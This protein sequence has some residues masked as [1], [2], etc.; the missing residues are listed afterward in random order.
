MNTTVS[1]Q[2]RHFARVAFDAEVQLHFHLSKEV[3][4]AHLL[5]IS[6][7]GALFETKQPLVN[8]YYGKVCRIELALGRDGDQI[9]I[10]G[11]VVHQEGQLI[12]IE[13][14]HIDLDS[15]I[16]LRRLVEL[17]TGDPELLERELSELIKNDVRGTKPAS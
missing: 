10:E 2:E 16:N 14:H 11:Q 9:I 17:N 15:M 6:L 3:Q 1:K 7:K 5:D 8:I 12:G 13:C 4:A